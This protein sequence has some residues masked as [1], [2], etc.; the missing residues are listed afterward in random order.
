MI[1][2]SWTTQSSPWATERL[3]SCAPGAA[4]PLGDIFLSSM[5]NSEVA[6]FSKEVRFRQFL[7]EKRQ[8]LPFCRYSGCTDSLNY[9]L[10]TTTVTFDGPN[11]RLFTW[12]TTTSLQYHTYFNNFNLSDNHWLKS[13]QDSITP[14]EFEF[15]S[16][17]TCHDPKGLTTVLLF[18]GPGLSVCFPFLYHSGPQNG[19]PA[20]TFKPPCSTR[21]KSKQL[22]SLETVTSPLPK[23]VLRW[24]RQE[25]LT[26]WIPNAKLACHYPRLKG[27]HITRHQS[28]ASEKEAGR[29]I[30][31]SWR[32][33]QVSTEFAWEQSLWQWWPQEPWTDFTYSGACTHG[34]DKTLCNRK[35][36]GSERRRPGPVPACNCTSPLLYFKRTI[37]P[38]TLLRMELSQNQVK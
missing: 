30:S 34:Q 28:R 10:A 32:L 1:A 4:T 13:G 26:V 3:A 9:F 31:Q 29:Y 12:S 7:K 16:L 35:Q 11:H 25:E 21:Y 6:N 22:S 27:P 36:H 33:G 2:P 8:Q 14:G 24:K 38:E 5:T 20:P 17:R 19:L 23:C 18:L 15:C 37:D